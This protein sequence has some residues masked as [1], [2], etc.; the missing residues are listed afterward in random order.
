MP[1]NEGI[2]AG[3]VAVVLDDEQPALDQR[4]QCR[5]DGIIAP[6]GKRYEIGDTSPPVDK[7]EQRPF[8]ARQRGVVAHRDGHGKHR[9]GRRN[10]RARVFPRF[11]PA[12]R[13]GH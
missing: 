5:D 6:A 10:H 2:R 8:G 7:S 11:E 13:V 3:F 9:V 4:R 1:A 12:T